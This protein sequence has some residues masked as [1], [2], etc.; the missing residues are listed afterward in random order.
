MTRALFSLLG[1]MLIAAGPTVAQQDTTSVVVGMS[2][3]LSGAQA[4]SASQFKAG[5]EACLS[6]VNGNVKLEAYD[7]AGDPARAAANIRAMAGRPSV[8][9]LLG[10]GDTNVTAAVVPLLEEVRLS[11]IGAVT[12]AASV[13][14]L[15]GSHLF[16][17]R[18]NYFDE[19]AAVTKQLFELGISDLAVVYADSAMGRE[20]LEGVRIETSRLAMRLQVIGL[21]AQGK[22][23]SVVKS[24]A[25]A[26]PSAVVLIASHDQAARLIRD[27]R[28][29]GARP[30][31][32]GLSSVSAERL[33]ADLGGAARGVGITQI[34]PFP[35][36]TKLEL[37]RDYQA[38]MKAQGKGAPG[39]DSLEGC[40][41]ARLA[42]EAIKRAGREPTRAKVYAALDK[43]QFDLGGHLI[44]FGN[45]ESP[46]QGSHFVEMTVIGSDMRV[47]R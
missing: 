38:A 25:Q 15:T 45:S 29:T 19:G 16:H 46:R 40:V 28:L 31:F 26:E 36:G 2:L 42:A 37:V 41:Y 44:R 7:D 6:A 12:G 24:V 32:V 23:D 3:P 43:G 11:M 5:A 27:I 1:F 30:R 10:G 18:A 35:W 33:S 4:I 13:R 22:F 39:Y 34:V 8:L 14:Q 17:G 9:L 20:G 21:P 47:T